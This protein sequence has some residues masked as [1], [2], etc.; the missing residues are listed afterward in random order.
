MPSFTLS[1]A[2]SSKPITSNI[3]T[4]YSASGINV[5]ADSIHLALPGGSIELASSA[6]W[7]IIANSS[8]K[9]IESVV[10]S[11]GKCR[12]T[13]FYHALYEL[14]HSKKWPYKDTKSRDKEVGGS[15]SQLRED[16]AES[17]LQLHQIICLDL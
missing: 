8:G 4:N 17:L 16:L 2:K 12:S 9:N 3:L 10:C 6:A 15:Q 11:C 13:S 7:K 1:E 14:T 5:V